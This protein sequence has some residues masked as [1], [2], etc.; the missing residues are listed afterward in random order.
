MTK[1]WKAADIP[2]LAGKRVL[3]TGA[4]SGIGYHAALKLVRKGAEVLLACRDQ[5]RGEAWTPILR[6]PRPSW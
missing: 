1:P 4:N 5:R 3:I 2:S 6:A